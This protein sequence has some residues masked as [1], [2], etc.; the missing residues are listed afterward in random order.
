LTPKNK[1][2]LFS[3]D[4]GGRNSVSPLFD[5]LSSKNFDLLFY[6]KDFS[7]CRESDPLDLRSADI[8][9][10][11]SIL[12]PKALEDWLIKINPKAVITGTSYGD[13]SERHLWLACRKL[14]IPTFAILDHWINYGVRFKNED[15]G[16]NF[17]DY[18]VVTDSDAEQLAIQ[19]GVP[20]ARLRTWGNP[21]YDFLKTKTLS[22]ETNRIRSKFSCSNPADKMILFASE[23]FSSAPQSYGYDEKQ[24]L[25]NLL[26][27]L[28][29]I[30]FK[31]GRISLVVR[32]HPKENAQG[33]ADI[34]EKYSGENLN[35]YISSEDKSIDI[36]LASD[37]VCGMISQFLIESAVMKKISVSIQIGLNTKDPFILTQKKVIP[38]INNIHQLDDFFSSFFRE[39]RKPSNFELPHHCMENILAELEKIL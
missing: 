10:E 5:F 9:N 17:P 11:V 32:P 26:Q 20:K 36:I 29:K 24:T 30:S 28:K 37:L 15:A 3:R 14:K 31:K 34:C 8:L 6:T 4:P 23:P 13:F 38:L 39:E 12:T 1:I 33:L 25:E 19:D 2:L 21:Y 27:S 35:I 22:N 16:F 18:I 7:N